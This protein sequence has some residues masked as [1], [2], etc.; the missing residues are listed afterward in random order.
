VIGR[1]SALT[2]RD[3]QQDIHEIGRALNI[4]TI[5][6]GAMQNSGAPSDQRTARERGRRRRALVDDA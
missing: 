4:S 5:L 1:T 6:V 3:H 2:F